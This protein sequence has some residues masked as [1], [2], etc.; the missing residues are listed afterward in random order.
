MYAYLIIIIVVTDLK[1][2]G[3]RRRVRGG[4]RRVHRK[5]VNTASIYKILKTQKNLKRTSCKL[6][7][8]FIHKFL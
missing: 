2:N 3:D 5:D 7:H 6:K 1:G 4:I 8:L